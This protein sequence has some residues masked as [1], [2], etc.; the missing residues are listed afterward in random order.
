MSNLKCIELGYNICKSPKQKI[1][2]TII[3]IFIFL[4]PI[5]LFINLQNLNFFIIN[6]LKTSYVDDNIK[7]IPFPFFGFLNLL[8]F[9][10]I[11]LFYIKNIV[12]NLNKEYYLLLGFLFL[13][14][15]SAV[16]SGYSIPSI[17]QLVLFPTLLFAIT[18]LN[19]DKK[20]AKYYILGIS[21]F[22]LVHLISYFVLNGYSFLKA[23]ERYI[24]YETVFYYQIYQGLI[25][26]VNVL[27][28]AALFVLYY[29]L[30]ENDL[31]K[32]ILLSF[33]FALLLY[34]SALSIQRLFLLDFIII[35]ILLICLVF[36]QK[37]IKFFNK[38]I[39]LIALFISWLL[40]I[41]FVNSSSGTSAIKRIFNTIVRLIGYS[42][43]KGNVD[44]S[45]GLERVDNINRVLQERMFIYKE[46]GFVGLLLGQG[47]VHSGSHN[48]IIDMIYGA[49]IIGTIFYFVFLVWTFIIF[50]RPIFLKRN[51]YH[52]FFI[53]AL[54]LMSGVGSMVNSPLTQ[55][56]YFLSLLFI[57]WS[58]VSA[59]KKQL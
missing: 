52:A 18:F 19:I 43:E 33:I 42:R 39:S 50:T 31:K 8:L 17:I 26:Y 25:S 9:I 24:V 41:F 14:I 20:Y 49:G 22:A 21:F 23:A 13:F 28:L 4:L 32:T 54:L 53:V 58:I 1:L 47:I 48:F 11:F 40:S 46:K 56:Y 44:I 7:K 15:I 16:L 10:I 59:S 36:F 30:Q 37:S 27:T 12:R 29:L 5:P 51:S 2:D 34:I 38:I 45:N 6:L 55:P 3:K 35:S 57:A